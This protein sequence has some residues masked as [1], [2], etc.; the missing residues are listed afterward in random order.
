MCCTV[1]QQ[2]PGQPYCFEHSQHVLSM[3]YSVNLHC[4]SRHLHPFVWQWLS[5]EF[6][7]SKRAAHVVTLHGDQQ[8]IKRTGDCDHDRG[9][10][11]PLMP[12]AIYIR[13]LTVAHHA[14]TKQPQRDEKAPSTRIP[15]MHF[16]CQMCL[17]KVLKPRTCKDYNVQRHVMACR[18]VHPQVLVVLAEG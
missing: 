6:C 14:L 3:F 12:V 9:A 16:E 4:R 7:P 8:Q 10:G 1:K 5:F 18:R 2:P 15:L 13:W 11:W 17:S